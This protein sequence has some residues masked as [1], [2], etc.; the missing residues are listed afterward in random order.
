MVY[1]WLNCNASNDD[2]AY[3]QEGLISPDAFNAEDLNDY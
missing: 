1:K 3:L 2:I